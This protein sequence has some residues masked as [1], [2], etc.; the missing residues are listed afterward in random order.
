MKRPDCSLATLHILVLSF[1]LSLC[2]S[3]DFLSS[4][5]VPA[6]LFAPF[7][8]IITHLPCEESVFLSFTL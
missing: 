5:L 4:Y 7:S 2:D 6:V 3:E 8:L 1:S